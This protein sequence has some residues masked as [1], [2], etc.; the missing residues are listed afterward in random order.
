M[1]VSEE[2]VG[3][4]FQINPTHLFMLPYFTFYQNLHLIASLLS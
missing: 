4:Y 1:S 2:V 3:V